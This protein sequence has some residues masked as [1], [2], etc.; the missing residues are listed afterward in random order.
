M[1]VFYCK[2][3]YEE[4]I[5]GINSETKI[6]WVKKVLMNTPVRL[7]LTFVRCLVA[8][9]ASIETGKQLYDLKDD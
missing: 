7:I 1:P 3:E 9:H 8:I 4:Y 6:P 5:A 2:A